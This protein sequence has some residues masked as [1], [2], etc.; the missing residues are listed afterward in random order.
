MRE[1]AA[2]EITATVRRLTIDAAHQLEPDL[3]DALLAARDREVSPLARGALDLLLVNA[4][5]ASRALI[6]ACPDT[7]LCTV[8]VQLGQEVHIAGDL[9]AAIQE[10][11][12]LGSAEGFLRLLVCDPV[13]RQNTGTNTPAVLHVQL[14]AGA[15]CR[16]ALLL[17]G[18]G[19]EN[20]SALRMLPPAA[21]PTGV[22]DF[23]VET[24]VQAGADPCPPLVVGVGVGGSFEQAALLAKQV[25]LRPLGEPHPEPAV[26]ALEREMLRRI[27]AEG[28]G[29]QGFGGCNTAL[30]VHLA[31]CPCHIAALPVAVNIQCHS[32]RHKM[33]TL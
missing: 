2:A 32:H 4:D 24:V 29:V 33:A 18:C 6:P 27:N 5:S 19:G 20:S 13:S 31:D 3:L 16:L 10:G 23:V 30:A 22:V 12:R 21:G 1:I 8:F 17:K 15:E 26:A 14:V 7:G 9:A 11:V 28:C 25:L